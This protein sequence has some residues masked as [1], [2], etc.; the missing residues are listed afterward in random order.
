MV[1][2]NDG[3][4]HDNNNDEDQSGAFCNTIDYGDGDDENN[5]YDWWYLGKTTCRRANVAFS[6]YGTLIGESARGCKKSTYINSFFTNAGI[7]PFLAAMQQVGVSYFQSDDVVNNLDSHCTITNGDVYNDDAAY[8]RDDDSYEY[9]A[10]GNHNEE[11]FTDMYSRSLFCGSRGRF[12]KESFTGPF[13]E[14]DKHVRTVDNLNQLN[15]AL[16]G[17]KCVEIYNADSYGQNNGDEHNENDDEYDGAV[18]LLEYSQ[19][20]SLR[21]P[22]GAC[23]DPHGKLRTYSRTLERA[24]KGLDPTLRRRRMRHTFSVFLIF[25]SVI[26]VTLSGR[27]LVRRCLR[28]YPSLRKRLGRSKFGR[29][30]KPRRRKRK[31]K[32]TKEAEGDGLHKSTPTPSQQRKKKLSKKEKR[33]LSRSQQDLNDYHEEPPKPDPS[34]ES[35]RK[36]RSPEK[37]A[38]KSSPEEKRVSRSSSRSPGKKSRSRSKRSGDVDRYTPRIDDGSRPD[39]EMPPPTRR[40]SQRSDPLLGAGEANPIVVGPAPQIAA[41]GYD[42]LDKEAQG[43]FGWDD[44]QPE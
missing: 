32:S 42:P 14:A 36:P 1:P 23:P 11:Y 18:A 31:K 33:R 10:Y 7:A 6:L 44:Q 34:P 9:F 20:C 15:N 2:D 25:L 8:Y 4:S 29:V 30:M 24:T 12:V 43:R 26:M 22:S 38:S 39:A 40:T 19:S 16:S 5:P 41:E 27:I 3:Q 21:D 35:P 13:C 28:N 17:L 37:Q